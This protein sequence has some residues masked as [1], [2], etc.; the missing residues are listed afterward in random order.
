MDLRDRKLNYPKHEKM[1]LK[2]KR[3]IVAQH[4]KG[5]K[6]GGK[7]GRNGEREREGRGMKEGSEEGKRKKGSLL[8]RTT[9]EYCVYFICIIYSIP[10]THTILSYITT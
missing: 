8:D 2:M 4:P 3:K 7:N 1:D 9:L 6:K 5:Q 10:I